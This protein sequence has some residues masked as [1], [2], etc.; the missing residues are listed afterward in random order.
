MQCEITSL[1]AVAAARRFAMQP[2]PPSRAHDILRAIIE[3]FGAAL[4]LAGGISIAILLL[5]LTE[6]IDAMRAGM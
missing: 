5:F 4:V 1:Q 2:E 3:M 6:G